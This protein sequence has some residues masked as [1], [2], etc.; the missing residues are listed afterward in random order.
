[1]EGG[2]NVT[3]DTPRDR[4]P[5]RHRRRDARAD[6]VRARRPR[7][8]DARST[9]GAS[10]PTR[11]P[12]RSAAAGSPRTCPAP[13]TCRPRPPRPPPRCSPA[14]RTRPASTPS[15]SSPLSAAQVRPARAGRRRGRQPPRRHPVHPR[16]PAR[17]R[18]RAHR[19]GQDHPH[20]PPARQRGRRAAEHARA[21]RH[22]RREPLAHRV[23]AHR[24][25]PG[26][27]L[28]LHRRRGARDARSGCRPRSSA[29]TGCA[30][31]CGSSAPTRAPTASARTCAPAPT[32]PTSAPRGSG[33]ATSSPA[34]DGV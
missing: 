27:V 13:C 32:T 9:S 14:T 1:M 2:V 11:T 30:R 10:P 23:A 22:A 8:D 12:G 18:A 25:L 16:R 4:L 21:V 29:C 33:C 34:G 26:P 17:L 19:G 31:R 15:L 24:R 7:G 20:G 6:R 5:A 28:L 3:L